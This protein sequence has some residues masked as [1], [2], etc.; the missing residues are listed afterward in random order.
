MEQIDER[1]T[2]VREQELAGAT[3]IGVMAKAPVAGG[4]KTRL[5]V[6]LGPAGAAELAGCFLADTLTTARTVRGSRLRIVCPD[7]SHRD[8]LACLAPGTSIV[9]QGRSGLMD[10]L[11]WA[12]ASNFAQGAAKVVLVDADS[13]DLPV[14][15]LVEAIERLDAVDLC[16]GPCPDG[17]YYLI[18][19][20]RDCPGLLDD[21]AA[22]TTSTLDETVARARQ[23]A[24]SVGLLP[25]WPDVDTPEDFVRLVATLRANGAGAPATRAW[26]A[27]HGWLGR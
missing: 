10:G 3:V 8:G 24:Y 16:F 19:A 18:G 26:L 6:L 25:S 21:V 11:A 14:R 17:G 27:R 9:V 2:S 12:F 13:P 22:S 7:E 4:A 15:L 5:A 1:G 20:R 23:L